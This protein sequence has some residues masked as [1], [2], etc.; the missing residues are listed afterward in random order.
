MVTKNDI[1]KRRV[2][3]FPV[4]LLFHRGTSNREGV[5]YGHNL[6]AKLCWHTATYGMLVS[7]LFEDHLCIANFLVCVLYRRLAL[8]AVDVALS[9]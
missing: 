8:S 9:V 3:D 6:M 4:I 2:A 1:H 7:R 5:R